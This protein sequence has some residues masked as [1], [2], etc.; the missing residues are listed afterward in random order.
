MAQTKIVTENDIGL[1]LEING[2]KLRAAI[3]DKTIKVVDGKL[4]ATA[5]VDLRLTALVADKATGKLKATVADKDGGND[6][7]VETSLAD[8]IAVSAEADNLVV[9]KADGLHVN[10]ADVVAAAKEAADVQFT[11]LGGTTLGY[12]FES[13]T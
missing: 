3:D 9:M 11:S 5:S 4:V 10:K 2:N 8:L 13:N 7:T 6:V 12:A 1:G